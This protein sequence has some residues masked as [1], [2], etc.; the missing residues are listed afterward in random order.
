ML[1]Q[2]ICGSGKAQLK[3]CTPL[4]NGTKVAK[5]PVQLMRSR[6]SAYAVGGYGE[7]LLETWLPVMTK[8]LTAAELSVRSYEWIRLEVISKSQQGD[9]GQVEFKAF[10]LNA[11]GQEAVQHENSIFRRVKG[12][13]YYVGGDLA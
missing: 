1:K 11:N 5:T 3:C 9:T 7:Y 4:L 8:G 2:C 13:W 6:Y 10:Y 12:R